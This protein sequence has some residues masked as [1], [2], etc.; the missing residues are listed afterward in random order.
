MLVCELTV[1]GERQPHMPIELHD[2]TFFL[3]IHQNGS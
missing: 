1:I 2:S 3:S